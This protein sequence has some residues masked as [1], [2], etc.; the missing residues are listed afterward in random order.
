MGIMNSLIGMNNTSLKAQLS[1][2]IE[3]TKHLA[4]RKW[5]LEKVNG[6]K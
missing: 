3:A 5:L 1:A 4:E 6:V 2:E